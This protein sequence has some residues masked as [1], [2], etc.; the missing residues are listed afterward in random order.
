[1]AISGEWETPAEK[2]EQRM[3]SLTRAL[4]A[5]DLRRCKSSDR[6]VRAMSKPEDACMSVE[7]SQQWL[8]RL[9]EQGCDAIIPTSMEPNSLLL[10][11]TDRRSSAKNLTPLS[12]HLVRWRDMFFQD[13]ETFSGA[14]GHLTES[15]LG[16]PRVRS[17][18]GSAYEL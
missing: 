1:M 11:R 5:L 12:S 15:L 17:L 7:Y 8:L 4:L 10:S 2:D 18:S 9:V 14:A 6:G 16:Q 13:E 3:H